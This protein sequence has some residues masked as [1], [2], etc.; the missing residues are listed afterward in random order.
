M[1]DFLAT[2]VLASYPDLVIFPI[3]CLLSPLLV[4]HIG[5]N[6]DLGADMHI[7]AHIRE[8]QLNVFSSV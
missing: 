5:S 2:D 3:S 6:Y 4:L 1:Y 8:G 7:H